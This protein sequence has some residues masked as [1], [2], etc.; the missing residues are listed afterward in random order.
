MDLKVDASDH[1]P[2][3]FIFKETDIYL[4]NEVVYI[5]RSYI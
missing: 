5:T 1:G 2:V 3:F 4:H